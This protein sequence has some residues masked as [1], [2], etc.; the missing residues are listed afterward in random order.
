[1]PMH[2]LHAEKAKFGS[3]FSI[4]GQYLSET[5]S[6]VKHVA[7]LKTDCNLRYSMVATLLVFHM[8]P[9]LLARRPFRRG[10]QG[11]SLALHRFTCSAAAACQWRQNSHN[12]SVTTRKQSRVTEL[13]SIA[14]RVIVLQP[15]LSSALRNAIEGQDAILLSMAPDRG[16]SY[17]TAYLNTAAS[18]K[19][20][21]NGLPIPKHILYTS[22]TSIYGD[23]EG[24]CV[25]ESTR[26]VISSANARILLDTENVLLSLGKSHCKVCILRLGEIYGPGREIQERLRHMARRTMPGTGKS[27]TNMIHVDDVLGA[28]D[29]ALKKDLEGV[30]N[31]C[32]DRHV[33]RKEFYDSICENEGIP[34]IQWDPALTSQH[35]GN[36]IVSNTKIKAAGFQFK[37]PM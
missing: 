19:D 5:S 10:R 12:I 15:D 6:F 24:T 4:V 35:A 14:N 25:E 20:A 9:P 3:K 34:K 1:M 7:I 29:F 11:I 30:F 13:G 21:L 18:F 26:P 8:G 27:M 17:E 16:D 32:N 28:L 23:H 33:P 2:V 31:L 37:H 22:S 36:K